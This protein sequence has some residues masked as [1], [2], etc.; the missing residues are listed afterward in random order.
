MHND[1]GIILGLI[2]G[3]YAAITTLLIVLV[4]FEK[5][6]E[7]P[8]EQ[9]RSATQT[10]PRGHV[11]TKPPTSL[12]RP[13]RIVTVLPQATCVPGARPWVRT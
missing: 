7:E 6:L 13:I 5:T 12:R 8:R 1:L 3:T 11:P 10:A 9:P 4:H 2:L